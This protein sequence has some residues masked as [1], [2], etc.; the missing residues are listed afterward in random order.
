MNNPRQLWVHLSNMIHNRFSK[1]SVRFPSL[2]INGSLLTNQCQI[3]NALNFHFVSVADQISRKISVAQDTEPV[4]SSAEP[5]IISIPFTGCSVSEDEIL[6]IIA[7]MSNSKAKDFYGISNNLLKIHCKSLAGP[8]SKLINQCIE[9]GM[10]PSALKIA[11]VLPLSKG[12]NRNN[13]DNTRPI[14]KVP[15]LSKVFEYVMV[16][17]WQ[18]HLAKNNIINEAQFGFVNKSNTEA[19]L[20]HILS[21]VYSRIEAKLFT[22]AVFIDVSK[23]FDCVDH[24][25]LLRKLKSLQMPQNYFNLFKSCFSNRTQLVEI[26][27]TR[28]SSLN[29]HAGVFQGSILGPK[30][31]IFYINDIFKLK[32]NGQIQLYADDTTIVYGEESLKLL[33]QAIEQDVRTIR[34]FFYSLKLD[35]NA[36]K[37]KYVLFHGRKRLENFTETNLNIMDGQEIIERVPFFKCLGLL[38]DERL[39]FGYHVDFVYKKCVSMIYAIKRIRCFL[40]EKLA[41]QLYYAHI[42]SH[43]IFLIPLWGYTSSDN[44]NRLFVLQKWCLRIIR[45]KPRLTPSVS[46]FSLKVLPL[47]LVNDYHLL[48]LAFKVKHNLIKNNISLNYVSNVH[49]HGTRHSLS[50]NFYVVS[51]QTNYGAADFYRRGLIKYN[52][53]PD[54]LKKI[55]TL[56]VFKNRIREYLFE[57]FNFDV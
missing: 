42:Y 47:P 4:L 40:T 36:S 24:D 52:E 17:R 54:V 26:D 19:A 14:A 21:S 18:S 33:K 22:A 10:F 2:E 29:I 48:L 28:S 1:E 38:I 7:N 57:N 20:M 6:M 23:A 53:L 46:L 16:D 45:I 56:N 44:L 27:G 51:H 39:K 37:T 8:I 50:G 30:A 15:I 41:F 3:A 49:A 12:G 32:L 25:I 35:L 31:F 55:R 5:P 11:V 13:P 43:L 9:A 34:K